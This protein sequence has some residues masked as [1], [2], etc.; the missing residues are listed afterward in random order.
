V[1]E[2]ADGDRRLF[3]SGAFCGRSSGADPLSDSIVRVSGPRI[4]L[5]LDTFVV[6]PARTSGRWL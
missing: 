1:R 6:T 2:A 4:V 3:R 5:G